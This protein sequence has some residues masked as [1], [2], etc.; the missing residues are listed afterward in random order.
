M[1]TKEA[2]SKK[3]QVLLQSLLGGERTPIKRGWFY[4]WVFETRQKLD[5]WA[6]WKDLDGPRPECGKTPIS[7]FI[8]EFAAECP[9]FA[10][11]LPESCDLTA[12]TFLTLG[13]KDGQGNVDFVYAE[14][15][16]L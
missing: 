3:L 14:I 10:L 13:F 2:H 15:R 5:D 9:Q 1:T 6:N 11:L 16:V 7:E 8:S 4:G 12:V